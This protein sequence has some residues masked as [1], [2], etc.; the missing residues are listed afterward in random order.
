MHTDDLE[1]DKRLYISPACNFSIPLYA[2][3]RR[4]SSQIKHAHVLWIFRRDCVCACTLSR[5][6]ESALSLL[7]RMNF[8]IKAALEGAHLFSLPTPLSTYSP[9]PFQPFPP[10]GPNPLSL[11]E[12]PFRIVPR[13]FSRQLRSLVREIPRRSISVFSFFS[14]SLFPS[15]PSLSPFFLPVC[16][17]LFRPRLSRR[18][19][20]P[21]NNAC[22]WVIKP[23][24][25]SAVFQNSCRALQISTFSHLPL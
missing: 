16:L 15:P 11:M 17:A 23:P 13:H 5:E 9:G 6:R 10:P 4:S 21:R 18:A 24:S 25:R 14:F 12:F 7:S 19:V 2:R 3:S 8:A 1:R 20:E 22:A